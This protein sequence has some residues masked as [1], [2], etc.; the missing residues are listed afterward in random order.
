MIAHILLLVLLHSASASVPTFADFP[1]GGKSFDVS[2]V[3]SICLNRSEDIRSD[4][5]ITDYAPIISAALLRIKEAGGGAVRLHNGVFPIR[6]SIILRDK[7]C[8]IGD[9]VQNV[10]LRVA[11]NSSSSSPKQGVVHCTSCE[12]VVLRDL[13]IDANKDKQTNVS[14]DRHLAKFGVFLANVKHA[15]I[16]SI[17]VRGALSYGI[18]TP[19]M[20]GRKSEHVAI[21]SSVSDSCGKDGVKL[22]NIKKASMQRCD[23]VNNGRH[24]VHI[25]GG[26][27]IFIDAHASLGDGAHASF[28]GCGLAFL[29]K[30]GTRT[31]DV[32]AIFT[33]VHDA[34]RAG[35][36]IGPS[37]DVEVSDAVITNT[38]RPDAPCYVVD[39]GNANRFSI[40]RGHCGTRPT[41]ECK[42]LK[43]LGMCC[44]IECG[45]CGGVGCS[46]RMP[47]GACCV[48]V[49]RRGN[50]K[51]ADSDPPCKI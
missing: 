38:R 24:G 13:T 30:K 31:S 5:A 8:L 45:Y 28:G 10:V 44:P 32:L 19:G 33:R 12:K 47:G 43:R 46:R 7:T 26:N 41:R 18:D 40:V 4:P 6:S 49:I 35:V 27:K 3:W 1:Y 36:C 37:N 42:G 23:T 14:A 17:R 39:E 15:W 29:D 25:A 51:C 48:D 22:V 11:D 34:Y 16:M 50:I 20:Y 9:G 21:E 2:S